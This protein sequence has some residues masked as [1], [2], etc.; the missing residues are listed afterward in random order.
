[1]LTKYPTTTFKQT[2]IVSKQFVPPYH[3][4]TTIQISYRADYIRCKI[5][6]LKIM[7]RLMN[8][9]LSSICVREFPFPRILSAVE[10]IFVDI[11]FISLT[12]MMPLVD[13]NGSCLPFERLSSS[14]SYKKYLSLFDEIYIFILLINMTDLCHNV[15][16]QTFSIQPLFTVSFLWIL[17]Y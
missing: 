4:I 10:Y 8:N 7:Y 2:L 6:S 5:Y 9:I 13:V 1:M 11:V 12:G 14:R 17:S 16:Q 3:N 15:K